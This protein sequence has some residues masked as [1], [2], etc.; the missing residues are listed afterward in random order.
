MPETV[1]VSKYVPK[2]SYIK[3]KAE[4]EADPT[5]MIKSKLSF[6]SS[7][8]NIATILIHWKNETSL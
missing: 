3:E 4:T 5:R 8:I 1:I 6:H 7:S 2:D